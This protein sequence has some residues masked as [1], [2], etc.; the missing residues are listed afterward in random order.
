MPV[1]ELVVHKVILIEDNEEMRSLLN[2]LLDMEGYQVVQL[3]GAEGQNDILR[4]IRDNMP[5]LVILDAHLPGTNSFDL[6]QNVRQDSSIA[7]IQILMSSGMD[8]E[9]KS[10]QAGADGFIIKP[11]MPDDLIRKIKKMI[12]TT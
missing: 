5:H 12:G 9:T 11:Y 8:L 6:I 3:T 4:C 2:V 7:P 10:Y 1:K